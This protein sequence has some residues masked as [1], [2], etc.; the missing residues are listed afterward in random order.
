VNE[1][2]AMSPPAS[3]TFFT[4]VAFV[5][6]AAAVWVLYPEGGFAVVIVSGLIASAGFLVIIAAWWA[7]LQVRGRR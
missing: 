1:R 2:G 7:V 5:I 3:L 4:V 6:V